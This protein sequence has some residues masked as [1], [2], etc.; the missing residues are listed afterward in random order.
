MQRAPRARGGGAAGAAGNLMGRSPLGSY[1][2]INRSNFSIGN[3][4]DYLFHLILH[5]LHNSSDIFING[6]AG[7]DQHRSSPPATAGAG[8]WLQARI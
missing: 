6:A 4:E 2:V 5:H 1:S 3:A 7:A 8:W